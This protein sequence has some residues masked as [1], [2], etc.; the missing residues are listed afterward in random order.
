MNRRN[1]NTSVEQDLEATSD[2]PKRVAVGMRPKLSVVGKDPNYEYRIV[3]DY[4]GRVSGFKQDGWTLCT[5]SEVDTGSFRA[6][7][8]SDEGSLATFV[9]DG[10]TGLKAYVMKIRKDWFLQDQQAHEEN[11]R[12]MEKALQPNN[13]DGGYGSIKIDRSGRS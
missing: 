4:P 6:E 7:E 11:L 8:A 5:N 1:A 10:G 3:N 9:V 2:R 13:N 12:E